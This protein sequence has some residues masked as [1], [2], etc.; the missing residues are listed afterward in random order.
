VDLHPD[1]PTPDEA[2]R[3]TAGGPADPR[4]TDYGYDLAHE[5]PTSPPAAGRPRSEP[6]YVATDTGDDSGDYG[7][8]LAHE[9]RRSPER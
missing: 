5:S 6:T 3:A 4:S 8:D 9:L 1:E 2:R 7:Y